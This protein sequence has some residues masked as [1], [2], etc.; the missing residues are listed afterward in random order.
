MFDIQTGVKS[1]RDPPFSRAR[2]LYTSRG[3]DPWF[4][5]L[6]LGYTSF[7]SNRTFRAGFVLARDR[8]CVSALHS[9][10]LSVTGHWTTG[11]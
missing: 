3:D 2:R 6:L 1:L 5:I 8:A 4:R 10:L 11:H 9:F 7:V